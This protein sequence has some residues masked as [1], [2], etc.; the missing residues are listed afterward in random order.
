MKERTTFVIA[1]RLA[2]M[3]HADR[4]I[5]LTQGRVVESGTHP[6]PV[7]AHGYYASLVER[8]TRG[9]IHNNGER[10][11]PGRKGML[12]TCAWFEGAAE[13]T[14][15]SWNSWPGAVRAAVRRL[16]PAATA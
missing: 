1:H 6:E 7:H 12:P 14:G 9:L 10:T 16:G 15:T 5:V 4:T 2:T 3:V 11:S 13:I 8:H